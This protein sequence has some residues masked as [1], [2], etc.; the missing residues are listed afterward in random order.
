MSVQSKN[1]TIT[2]NDVE[3]NISDL[4]DDVKYFINCISNIDNQLSQIKMNQD[5][6]NL[7]R[8]GFSQRLEKLLE[9]PVSEES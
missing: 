1:P 3:Y 5:T 7:A 2:I 4:S 9:P 8:E 6:M